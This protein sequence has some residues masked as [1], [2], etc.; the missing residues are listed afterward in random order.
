[1]ETFETD[2]LIVSAGPAGF[3]ASALLA[4]AA[5]FIAWTGAALP[6]TAPHELW[7]AM[8]S[9]FGGRGSRAK[10]EL[11]ERILAPLRCI[12]ARSLHGPQRRSEALTCR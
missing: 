6:K 9:A 8:L 10:Y 7:C 5:R 4:R 11:G 12:V 2:A 3:A 1:M